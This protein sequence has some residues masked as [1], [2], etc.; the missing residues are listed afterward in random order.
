MFVSERWAAAFINSQGPGAVEGLEC[1]K[2]LASWVKSLPGAVFG[3]SAAKRLENLAREQAGKTGSS[4]AFEKAIRITALL[5]RKN[6]FRHIDAVIKEIEKILDK[7]QGIVPVILESAFPLEGGAEAGIREEVKR[8]I[9]AKEV[10]LEKK[11]SPELI[12]GYRLHIGDE[13]VDA[14]VCLQLREMAAALSSRGN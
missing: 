8:R 7:K 5:V 3:S 11:I 14:S 10:R 4:P 1:L 2:I 9:G 13:L 6:L 12:G